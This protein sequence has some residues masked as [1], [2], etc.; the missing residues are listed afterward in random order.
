[1]GYGHILAPP[2]NA[3]KLYG[4]TG[5]CLSKCPGSKS[6]GFGKIHSSMTFLKK[7]NTGGVILRHSVAT[8]HV[9]LILWRSSH[10][11]R[12]SGEGREGEGT[13]A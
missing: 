7:E 4:G 1:M 9:Y 12:R 11:K 13:K 10:V 8:L 5:A 3:T 6:D 2:P